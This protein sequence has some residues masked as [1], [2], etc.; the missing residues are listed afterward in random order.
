[1]GCFGV[2]DD[3]A[4]LPFADL[5]PGTLPLTRPKTNQPARHQCVIKV[6]PPDLAIPST[7]RVMHTVLDICQQGFDLLVLVALLLASNNPL[8]FVI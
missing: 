8:R 2:S 5:D 1:M 4:A 7:S 3:E 6:R